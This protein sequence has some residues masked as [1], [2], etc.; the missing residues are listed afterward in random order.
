MATVYRSFEIQFQNS[1]NEG[2]SLN[3][4]LLRSGSWMQGEQP[5]AG[6][7]FG[8]GT[9][10]GFWGAESVEQN[11]GAAATVMLVGQSQGVATITWEMPWTGPLVHQLDPSSDYALVL[12]ELTNSPDTSHVK[13]TFAL[14]AKTKN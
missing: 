9:T 14:V 10:I 12:S 13:W 2:L 6:G 1:T 8:P 3:A 7:K 5:Q 4:S 11:E